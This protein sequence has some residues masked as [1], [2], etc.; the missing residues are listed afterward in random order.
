MSL[1][2]PSRYDIGVTRSLSGLYVPYIEYEQLYHSYELLN[3]Q[4]GQY[5]A[6]GHLSEVDH[7]QEQLTTAMEEII[8]LESKVKELSSSLSHIAKYCSPDEAIDFA[9]SVLAKNS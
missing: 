2:K 3:D 6:V 7:Y 8:K 4:L 1:D 9:Q 5:E